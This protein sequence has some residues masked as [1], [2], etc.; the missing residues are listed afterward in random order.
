M[1]SPDSPGGFTHRQ[2]R[3]IRQ[4]PQRQR[5]H[6]RLDRAQRLLQRPL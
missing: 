6:L 2:D 3:G 5:H 1:E 4:R